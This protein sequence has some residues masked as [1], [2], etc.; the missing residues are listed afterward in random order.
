LKKLSNVELHENPPSGNRVIPRGNTDGY[1]NMTNLIVDLLNFGKAPKRAH[2]ISQKMQQICFS[3]Q[4]ST[5]VWRISSLSCDIT[6]RWMVV[7]EDKGQAVQDELFRLT[8][9]N[10]SDKVS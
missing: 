8:L 7:N 2:L 9:D 4:A 5:A 10:G 1:I 3:F 6:Q